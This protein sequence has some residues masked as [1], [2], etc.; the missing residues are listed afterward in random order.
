MAENETFID[1]LRIN[2]GLKTFHIKTVTEDDIK[3]FA[4]VSGD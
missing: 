1:R 2:V 3:K 4:E